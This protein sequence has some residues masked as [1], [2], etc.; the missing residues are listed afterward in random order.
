M[1]HSPNRRN[2]LIH[3]ARALGGIAMAGSL[4]AAAFAVRKPEVSLYD[5]A[6]WSM[7]TQV[8]LSI[9]RDAYSPL[10]IE[11]AF[12]EVKAV[13]SELSNHK[14]TSELSLLN[15]NPGVWRSASPSMLRVAE[16]AL[17]FGGLSSGALDVTVAPVLR[18]LGFI[19]TQDSDSGGAVEVIDY[20][21]LHVRSG[22]VLLSRGGYS[23]DFGGVAKGYAVD[24]AIGLLAKAHIGP[25]LLD[26][27]GDLYAKGRP[28]AGRRWRI[29][30][31][32]PFRT[33]E[34]FATLEVEDEAVATSGTYAQTRIVAGK[35][36]S[37]IID[38]RTARS[39]HHIVSATVITRNAVD[40][41]A[42][43]TA[44][45]VLPVPAGMDLIERLPETE[46]VVVEEDA[47]VTM[48]TGLRS[49]LHLV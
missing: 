24:Q 21:K 35:P 27:G 26:A 2:F 8:R 47:T 42:L 38:P 43:A 22:E 36:V 41:D 31:R 45:S 11:S 6:I 23:V 15:R 19:P 16:A 49:R 17:R 13:D 10:V 39:V 33:D 25:A 7:G 30:I 1:Q 12:R 44:I 28:E 9:Q 29:G 18:R 5:E 34:L 20:T 3:S 46:A 37:H 32:D 14:S 48:S 40:A 4:P